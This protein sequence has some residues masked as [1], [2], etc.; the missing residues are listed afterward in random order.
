MCVF[1]R[2]LPSNSIFSNLALQLGFLIG[3]PIGID[4]NM[5]DL[6]KTNNFGSHVMRNGSVSSWQK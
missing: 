6:I 4:Q 3:I 5:D 1:V 2:I